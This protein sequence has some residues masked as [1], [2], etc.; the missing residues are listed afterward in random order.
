MIP[1]EY[2]FSDKGNGERGFFRGKLIVTSAGA[3]TRI[4]SVQPGLPMKLTVESTNG[5]KPG[6]RFEYADVQISDVF[7]ILLTNST[8]GVNKQ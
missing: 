4:K 5:F 7:E 3:T 8:E 2:A 1:H 6:D